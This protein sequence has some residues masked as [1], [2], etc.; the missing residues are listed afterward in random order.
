MKKLLFKIIQPTADQRKE[1]RGWK[2]GHKIMLVI[3]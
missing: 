1:D 3:I 2:T